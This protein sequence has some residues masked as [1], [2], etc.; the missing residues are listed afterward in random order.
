MYVPPEAFDVVDVLV[1][2]KPLLNKS[3]TSV[4]DDSALDKFAY[5]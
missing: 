1:S 4:T 2:L 3:K 5:K